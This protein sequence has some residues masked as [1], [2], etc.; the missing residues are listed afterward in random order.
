MTVQTGVSA[1]MGR[2]P[3]PRP[4]LTALAG[5]L[6]LPLLVVFGG[7]KRPRVPLLMFVLLL[8][9][10]CGLVTACGSSPQT[11]AGT[12]TVQVVA[13]GTSGFQQTTSVTL[14]VQ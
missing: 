5:V 8:G 11:P 2:V 1:S 4:G 7:N 14:T 10:V 12:S 3:L 6:C 9:G 13:S